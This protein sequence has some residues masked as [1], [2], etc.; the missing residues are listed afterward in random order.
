MPDAFGADGEGFADGFRAGGFPGVVGE[1][2][3]GLGRRGIILA[4][5]FG[6]R[7]ALVSAE[8]D[9]DDRGIPGPHLGGLPEDDARLLHGEVADG[10]EDPVERQA[11]LAF[12][13]LPGS[14]Q[15]R[16]RWARSRAD[17]SSATCR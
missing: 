12:A 11:E 7:L 9:A 5:G 3:T 15:A 10:V 16:R 14:L 8:A 2:E 1:A 13:A 4:E 17:R 6:A